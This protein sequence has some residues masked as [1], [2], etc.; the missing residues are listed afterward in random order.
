MRLPRFS[1]IAIL[2]AAVASWMPNVTVAQL[3]EGRAGA[4]AD[5]LAA[6]PTNIPLRVPE[7]SYRCI[8]LKNGRHVWLGEAGNESA[9]AVLL[10]HGLGNYAHRDWRSVIPTLAERYRVIAVDLPGFGA[11]EALPGGYS[12]P[13]LASAL[14][15]V[16]DRLAVTR[17]HVVGHS[18]GASLSLYFAHVRSNRVERLILV[19]AAGI[20]QKSVFVRHM[21]EKSLPQSR[22]EPLNWL[23]GGLDQRIAGRNSVLTRME[24]RT[25][26]AAWL[27]ENPGVRTALLGRY[28]QIDAGLGLIE[29]DFTKAIR[30]VSASTTLIWG[31]EDSVAPLRTGTLLVSRM[32]NARLHVLDG[33][34]HVPMSEDPRRFLPLLLQALDSESAPAFLRSVPN[35]HQGRVVCRNQS[36]VVYSGY[37]ESLTLQRCKN[38]RIER[39]NLQQL[40]IIASTA[41]LTF[42]AID[43]SGV[44]LSAT[45]SDVMATG[46]EIRGRVAIKAEDSRLDLAGATLRATQRG[47][48]SATG[49]RIYLSVSELLTPEFAGDAHRIWPETRGAIAVPGG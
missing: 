32:R 14:T 17:A 25:D 29:H 4:C 2:I 42:V 35:R 15:E 9:P 43:S 16:L 20:L 3:S 21:V 8:A 39:A 47:I 31:R 23:L 36:N 18:L 33:V 48:E 30:E 11:S 6:E 22:F 41:T 28:T 37:F 12:F 27:M 38:V 34:G 49:S 5:R 13:Q 44:A 45:Q 46:L 26:L 19:D 7:L 40:S 1:V 10:V 24:E